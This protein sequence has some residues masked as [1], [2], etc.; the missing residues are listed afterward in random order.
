MRLIAR[1]FAAG[2][3]VGALALL[4]PAPAAAARAETFPLHV[5]HV[6]VRGL[7]TPECPP[8]TT[9]ETEVT[10]RIN[11]DAFSEVSPTLLVVAVE[12][13]ARGYAGRF[14]L[15]SPDGVVSGERRMQLPSCRELVHSLA[16]AV[17]VLLDTS[18]ELVA[19][20][21]AETPPP[22]EPATS[23][24]P[25]I[26]PSQPTPEVAVA[27]SA[28]TPSPTPVVTLAQRRA[29]PEVGVAAQRHW[30]LALGT[31]LDYAVVAGERDAAG[32]GP[33]LALSRV[34]TQ[35]ALG[36]ELRGLL[37]RGRGQKQ[38]SDGGTSEVRVSTLIASLIPCWWS[39]R[40]QELCAAVTAGVV[41]GHRDEEDGVATVT[42][43][44]VSVGLRLAR[45]LQIGG[46][47]LRPYVY[48]DVPLLRWRLM[49]GD[50]VSLRQGW[51]SG[52]VGLEMAVRWP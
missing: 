38:P 2:L 41:N 18:P 51:V 16:A 23:A 40:G 48:A 5:R 24:P 49:T 6:F 14:L 47:A 34:G 11:R 3:T 28:V 31:V 27:R 15:R 29:E 30:E 4:A 42:R 44:T 50:E 1:A 22:V 35:G 52:G 9:F 20:P 39:Q 8:D 17:S 12:R 45:R 43:P 32:F 37:P 7:E 10:R 46:W 33:T 36:V 19:P 21:I 26:A 13:Q 25:E